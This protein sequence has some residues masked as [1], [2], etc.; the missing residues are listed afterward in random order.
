MQQAHHN[1]EEVHVFS[2]ASSFQDLSSSI[3]T[4]SKQKLLKAQEYV[5]EL[6]EYVVYNAHLSWLVGPF[7]PSGRISAPLQSQE[8]L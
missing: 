6:F 8:D 7:I 2:N 3:L 5:D 4:C 1:L